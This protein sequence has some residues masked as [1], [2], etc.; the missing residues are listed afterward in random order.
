[1]LYFGLTNIL[2]WAAEPFLGGGGAW[3][4]FRFL[5]LKANKKLRVVKCERNPGNQSK[6]RGKLCSKGKD[7]KLNNTD[8]S[9]P[10]G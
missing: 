5:C 4:W 8:Q 1:M 10:L 7:K 2:E 6:I 9:V 3:A